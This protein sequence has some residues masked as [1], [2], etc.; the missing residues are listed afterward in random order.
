MP[1]SIV[2]IVVYRLVS[3]NNHVIC[4]LFQQCAMSDMEICLPSFCSYVILQD[5]QVFYIFWRL[6]F[7]LLVSFA[8]LPQVYV[9]IVAIGLS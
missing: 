6:F 2:L 1:E 9:Y 5:L 7:S 4:K 3:S 8:S